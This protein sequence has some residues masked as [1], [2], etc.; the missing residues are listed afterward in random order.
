MSTRDSPAILDVEAAT[1]TN[2]TLLPN[3]EITTSLILTLFFPFSSGGSASPPTVC[4]CC[5]TAK[6]RQIGRFVNRAPC[7]S[8]GITSAYA[9]GSVLVFQKTTNLFP[10][11]VY[12]VR[13]WRFCLQISLTEPQSEDCGTT[14]AIFRLRLCL[15]V[16][17]T[18]NL[19]RL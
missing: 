4:P 2:G 12:T 1:I 8:T 9:L 16:S 14:Y 17:K 3:G 5:Y 19:P 10:F 7:V 11:L 15:G 13:N 18:S 6:R